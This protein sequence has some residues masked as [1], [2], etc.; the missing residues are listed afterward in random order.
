MDSEMDWKMTELPGL[1]CCGHQHRVPLEDGH[2]WSSQGLIM[3]P[4][5][6]KLFINVLDGG[7]Q[8]TLSKFADDKKLWGVAGR[9]GGCAA[10]LRDL[11][12]LEKCVNMNG[13]VKSC[14]WGGITPHTHKVCCQTGSQL[15]R[16][17]PGGSCWNHKLTMCQKCA[18]AL[19][20]TRCL[21]GCRKE[22][23]SSR[24]RGSDP[25]PLMSPGKRYLESQ[26][27]FWARQYK[28]KIGT[29][30]WVHQRWLRFWSIQSIRRGWEICDYSVWRKKGLGGSQQCA[31]LIGECKEYSQ[32]QW[33]PIK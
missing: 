24:S 19:G 29:L 5:L 10:V 14:S 11:H 3:W 33:C 26:V 30:E 4:G 21:L 20:E 8:C 12:R 16:E 22:S 7:T 17:G 15:C 31:N 32:S 2:S 23:I 28:R 25:S 27:H 1:K 13:N 6:C 18:S 9:Q